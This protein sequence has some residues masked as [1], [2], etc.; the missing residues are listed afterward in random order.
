MI[1]PHHNNEDSNYLYISEKSEFSKI[2]AFTGCPGTITKGVVRETGPDLCD[3]I[4]PV[5]FLP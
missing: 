5:L 3:L 1:Y 4:L 2:F